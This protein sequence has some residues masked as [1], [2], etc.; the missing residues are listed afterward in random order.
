[1]EVT[2]TIGLEITPIMLAVDTGT[3]KEGRPPSTHQETGFIQWAAKPV[4]IRI[5][6]RPFH[7]TRTPPDSEGASQLQR[8]A[9]SGKLFLLGFRPVF[10]SERNHVVKG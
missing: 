3:R 4:T 6:D 1:M 7:L 2:F 10:V 8:E 5:Q 9:L